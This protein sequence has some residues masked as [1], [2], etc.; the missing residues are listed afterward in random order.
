MYIEECIQYIASCEVTKTQCNNQ[1]YAF[2]DTHEKSISQN[3]NIKFS[4]K[5][6]SPPEFNLE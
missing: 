1:F 6:L 2:K 3:E 4:V 5:K